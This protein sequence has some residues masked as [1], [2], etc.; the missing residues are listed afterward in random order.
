V[1]D[2]LFHRFAL[3]MFH[4]LI[5][6]P[7]LAATD[8]VDRHDPRVF[9]PA[10]DPNL[11]SE[12]KERLLGHQLAP[13]LFHRDGTLYVVVTDQFDF[14]HRPCTEPSHMMKPRLRLRCQ[15]ALAA[16]AAREDGRF[17]AN[18]SS[19][20]IAHSP[21]RGSN[22]RYLVQ[23]ENLQDGCVAVKGTLLRESLLD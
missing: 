1:V 22:R 2:D 10:N 20:V 13:Y 15:D 7:V 5:D 8:V 11:V 12:T 14:A 4:H 19:G 17:D 3:E 9:Q 6:S 21:Y 16:R 23:H 18:P